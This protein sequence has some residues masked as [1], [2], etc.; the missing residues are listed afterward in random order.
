MISA[1]LPYDVLIKKGGGVA[2]PRRGSVM[3]LLGDASLV[4]LGGNFGTSSGAHM[5]GG[6]SGSNIHS[7]KPSM[8]EMSFGGL[9]VTTPVASNK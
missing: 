5:I 4:N 7:R 6:S 8:D 1:G 3:K 9:G 2:P